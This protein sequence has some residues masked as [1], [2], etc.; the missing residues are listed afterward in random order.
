MKQIITILLNVICTALLFSQHRQL[1]QQTDFID[2]SPYY[3]FDIA[4]L[5]G[6]DVSNTHNALAR[7]FDT[8]YVNQA[9]TGNND[10]TSWEDAYIDLQEAIDATATND[11]IWVAAGT[12]KPRIIN[13]P[14]DSNYFLIRRPVQL[15]GGF[16]GTETSI[17]QRDL[18][19]SI[20]R[21]SADINDDD[22]DGDYTTNKSDNAGHLLIV[23]TNGSVID[24]FEFAYGKARFDFDPMTDVT[25]NYVGGAII[26][27][28]STTVRNSKFFENSADRGGAIYSLRYLQIENCTFENNYGALIGGAVMHGNNN[29][30]VSNTTFGNNKVGSGVGAGIFIYQNEASSL[31]SSV[32]NI[33]Q[34]VFFE[35]EAPSYAG[36]AFNNFNSGS[37]VNIDSCAFLGN[38][39]TMSAGAMAL[40]NLS[41]SSQTK[42][43]SLSAQVTNSVFDSNM[44]SFG[45]ALYA[46]QRTDSSN[47]VWENNTVSNNLSGTEGALR[48]ICMNNSSMQFRCSSSNFKDNMAE[49]AGAAI[50]LDNLQDQRGLHFLIDSCTFENN[51]SQAY[52]GA[53][54]IGNSLAGIGTKGR[55]QDC[56]FLENSAVIS[57]GAV[58][59]I[60]DDIEFNN[61]AF[62]SNSSGISAAVLCLSTF[63][64][65]TGIQ[66]LTNCRFIE[67]TVTD[68]VDSSIWINNGAV[69]VWSDGEQFATFDSC[70]FQSNIGQKGGG[71]LSLLNED[72][73]RVA[74][75]HCQF[76][77]NEAGYGAGLLAFGIDYGPKPYIEINDCSFRNNR[78]TSTGG[79][80][81]FSNS[82]VQIINCAF[83]SN[84]AV[85]QGGHLGIS[86]GSSTMANNCTFDNSQSVFGGAIASYNNNPNSDELICTFYNSEFSNNSAGQQGGAFIN[87]TA[88]KKSYLDFEN[89]MFF[90]NQAV[91]GGAIYTFAN[92]PMQVDHEIAL[93]V[94]KSIFESNTAQYRGGAIMNDTRTDTIHFIMDSCELRLNRTLADD[95]FGGGAG[96]LNAGLGDGNLMHYDIRNTAFIQNA[97][98]GIS[99]GLWN[100]AGSPVQ[101]PS[102][103]VQNCRFIE[104][105]ATYCC[106]GLG[107]AF[108]KGI[109]TDCYF[110]GN[111]TDGNHRSV[112]GGGAA[113]FIANRKVSI[114]NSTFINN[115][116]KRE[117]AA[118]LL[119]DVGDYT[120]EG[121]D[122]HSHADNAIFIN[123]D[124][125]I[126]NCSIRE[127]NLGLQTFD[128]ADVHL[129]NN[130][131]Q[132]V[133][134]WT[135]TGTIN[136]RGSNIS[137]DES[138]ASIFN[139]N[140]A[141]PDFNNTDAELNTMGSPLQGSPCVDAG[142]PANISITVDVAGNLRVQGNQIDIGA[143]ESPFMVDVT[144]Y[145]KQPEAFSIFPNPASEIIN[146]QL[147]NFPQD[148]ARIKIITS[149]GKEVFTSSK[150]IDQVNINHLPS[151]SYFILLES[152]NE[153]YYGQ[154]IKR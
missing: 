5:E 37:F 135:G 81:M 15:Y 112:N 6:F 80:G 150:L 47:L 122:I 124:A 132:N 138:L 22:I 145:E 93:T 131:F 16:K 32:V 54:N 36:F 8:V 61:C 116:S 20:T 58:N 121:L 31:D 117:G 143:F 48:V 140:G 29:A 103:I 39:A 78:A 79:A 4:P 148:A 51:A 42:P 134:N 126:I 43:H 60:N 123:A 87:L 46:I 53:I 71:A 83:D 144:T 13:T 114:Q 84:Q 18:S 153:K 141:F 38:R 45:A 2:E 73:L 3:G 56:T 137:S 70:L 90:E 74:L 65:E 25:I 100:S 151:G 44:A 91:L 111:S 24:G 86:N 35:N 94:K 63:M 55:I 27:L 82:S 104:N 129:Q 130:I 23:A 11:E 40:S 67:N 128:N 26:N 1:P 118:I 102:G 120:L 77:E 68:L 152:E 136:S 119:T 88:F 76:T 108:D 142:N 113:G 57:C 133:I 154:F 30:D 146:L 9:A 33:K 28:G 149:A 115:M 85:Q 101:G 139:Q 12:Y 127:N 99:G 107:A 147:V 59:S 66:K 109:Y 98:A 64:G 10:G 92:S 97:S 69:E 62:N 52:A 50:S 105:S 19:S 49:F 106:G 89:C 21:L 34:C 17:D 41:S 96:I 72:S 110:E 7:S 95:P 14:T 75:N 125:D